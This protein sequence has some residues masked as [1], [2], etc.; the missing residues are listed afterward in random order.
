MLEHEAHLA[1]AHMA[2]GCILAVEDDLPRICVVEPGDD[3]KQRGLA[4]ARWPEQRDELAFG[5]FEAHVVEREEAPER[6]PDVA[7]FDA[8]GPSTG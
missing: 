7:H 4:A 5:K 3:P 2:A 8:H 6:L 1:L